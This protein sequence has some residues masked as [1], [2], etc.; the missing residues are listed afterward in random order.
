MLENCVCESLAHA[1]IGAHVQLLVYT[2]GQA[3]KKSIF[4]STITRAAGLYGWPIISLQPVFRSTQANRTEIASLPLHPSRSG[5]ATGRQDNTILSSPPKQLTLPSSAY[6]I[7]PRPNGRY[8]THRHI[9]G[10]EQNKQ[11]NLRGR[12]S[13]THTTD[14]H[15]QY[16]VSQQLLP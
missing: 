16:R 15:T 14:H 5:A 13:T 10:D 3:T 2:E 9:D 8:P 1:W 6:F 4:F 12:Q 7:C 11:P